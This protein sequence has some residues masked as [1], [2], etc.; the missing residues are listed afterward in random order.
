MSQ[1]KTGAVLS[2]INIF[3]NVIIG[4][5]LTPYIIR[6]LGDSEYGLY[7]LIGSFVAY[8]S[9]MDLGLNN[10]II[11]YVSRFRAQDDKKGEE[12]FLGTVMKIY[13]L[14]SLLLIIIGIVIYVNLDT[15]FGKTLTI[16]QLTDA[17][18]MF[19]ILV[20]NIAV[21]LPGGAFTAISNAY[22]KFNFPRIVSIVRY[23]MRALTIVI[24]LLAGGKALSIV[25][26][27]TIF[28]FLLIGIMFLF[29]LHKEKV[30]FDFSEWD[31]EL[32]KQ[33]FSYSF[34]IF[35]L[36]MIS[37]LQWNSGQI[38]LG[39]KAGTTEVAVY[40][41]G[42]MLGTYYGTFSGAF[43]QL[44]LPRA[45]HMAIHSNK[46]EQL[47]MMIKIGRISFMVLMFILFSFI[48]LGKE[49]IY[50]WVGKSYEDAWFIALIIMIGYTI[51]L[52]QTFANSLVEA[53]NKVSFKAILYLFFLCSGLT[54]GYFLM[55]QYQGI[56]IAL[57]LTLGWGIAQIIMNIFFHQVLNLNML[58][59]FK[60]IF[61]N[62]LPVLT[63]IFALL[64]F[65][66][67]VISDS[68]WIVFGG[69]VIIFTLVF[70]LSLFFIGMNDDEKKL[71]KFKL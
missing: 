15:I 71:I 51:P 66:D 49:F 47:K 54:I 59:F 40:G 37:Q 64:Y 60:E 25:I 67:K 12:V 70:W 68:N 9:L 50:L 58:V 45:S 19:Q 52:M 62:L 38:L 26:V 3:L 4:L 35:V 10:T 24:V 7:T 33:I 5:V 65:I 22:E 20:L 18:I 55:P 36:G 21:T 14:I 31:K 30:K 1:I 53:Y 69:K 2:Y 48:I 34:W 43:S 46:K 23:V 17:K 61:K 27:D 6:R 57:G 28:N 32:V 42:I 11:R 44:F 63:F 29:V 13:L 16:A 39:M 56:G 8:L 41:V